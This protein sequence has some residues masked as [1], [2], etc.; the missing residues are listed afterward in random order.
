[1]ASNENVG[2]RLQVT[3][4]IKETA[5]GIAVRLVLMHFT[6]A[7]HFLSLRSSAVSQPLK[8]ADILNQVV[9]IGFLFCQQMEFPHSGKDPDI[10]HFTGKILEFRVKISLNLLE[11]IKK[12]MM[13]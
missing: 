13:F 10:L 2:Q 11:F 6:I 3:A 7:V 4:V 5:T 12:S 1:M 9:F 8:S